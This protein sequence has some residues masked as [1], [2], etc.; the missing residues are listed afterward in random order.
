MGASTEPGLGNA[1]KLDMRGKPVAEI[2]CTPG[3]PS[4]T[5]VSESVTKR[6]EA[7]GVLP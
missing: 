3:F 2:F 7:R 6:V 1:P 5:E 4:G